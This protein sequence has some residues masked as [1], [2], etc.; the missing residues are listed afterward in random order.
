M[1]GKH[2]CWAESV[3]GLPGRERFTVCRGTWVREKLY[4]HRALRKDWESQNLS[5][6]R[7]LPSFRYE[8][9]RIPF[10]HFDVYRI[11]D[12]EEM[13]EV[14]LDEYL[15]GDGVC[16]IEWADLIEDLLPEIR[17]EIRIKKD[18]DRGFDFRSIS[19][20]KL[21]LHKEEDREVT[22]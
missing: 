15:E 13:Y 2:F 14:G 3:P 9:G 11:S 22:I 20:E 7:H 8:D 12:P 6:A 4:L 19:I 18:L 17:T 10:Y 1:P 21:G 16:L 5:A